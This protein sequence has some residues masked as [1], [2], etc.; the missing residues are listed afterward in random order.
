MG[1]FLRHTVRQP[2]EGADCQHLS[3]VGGLPTQTSNNL[4][5]KISTGWWTAKLAL[6]TQTNKSDLACGGVALLLGETSR[7]PD[8]SVGDG[9]DQAE[10][11]EVLVLDGDQGEGELD[12]V[13]KFL[14]G[15]GG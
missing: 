4:D 15:C 14:V 12:L 7:Q 2:D 8:A 10:E 9:G 3:L 6:P 5:Q 1:R 11:E 13:G